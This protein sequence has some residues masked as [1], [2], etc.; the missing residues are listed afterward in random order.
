MKKHFRESVYY[1]HYKLNLNYLTV[2]SVADSRERS[3]GRAG[4]RRWKEKE[5]DTAIFIVTSRIL[6]PHVPRIRPGRVLDSKVTCELK[7]VTISAGHKAQASE[8]QIVRLNQLN[9]LY[10]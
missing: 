4:E 8:I 9:E 5:A 7:L 1:P 3:V 2:V 6:S 10:L